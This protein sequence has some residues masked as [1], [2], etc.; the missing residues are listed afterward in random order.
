ML[1]HITNTAITALCDCGHALHLEPS[2]KVGVMRFA[3]YNKQCPE[4]GAIYLMQHQ[5]IPVQREE[6]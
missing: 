6:P 2:P 5:M 1:T 4:H 3:C